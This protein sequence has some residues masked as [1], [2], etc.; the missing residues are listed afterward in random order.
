MPS[1]TRSQSRAL[2]VMENALVQTSGY[3][4]KRYLAIERGQYTYILKRTNMENT[5][6]LQVHIE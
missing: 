3:E 4:H 5:E 2:G 1:T 6:E